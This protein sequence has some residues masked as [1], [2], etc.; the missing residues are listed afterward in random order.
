M[1][2]VTD[3]GMD[4]SPQQREGIELHQVPL[5]IE[6]D[7]RTYRS[8]EDIEPGAFY[9]LLANTHSYP[10]TT[11][12]SPGDFAA[13]YRRLAAD[14][15]DILSVHISSGLSGTINAA[16]LGAEMVPEANVTL[17]D[18]KTLSGG[19]GW[20]VEAA[21]RALKAGWPLDAILELLARIRAAADTMFTLDELRYLVHGGRISHIK[22][23]LAQVL[24]IRPVIG[25]EKVLGKY[26]Q[27]GQARTFARATQ[28]LV[29]QVVARHKPGSPLR[30]QIM[31]A[32][33][34]EGAAE[35]RAKLDAVFACEWLPISHIAPVLGAHT[36]PSMIGVVF[37]PQ[38]LFSELPW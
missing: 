15:P 33:N 32:Y 7:G 19:E 29:D 10:T 3:R 30:L 4:L 20:Q 35:L 8:G 11:Q 12:P 24:R 22:G 2:I 25:V 6:L 37:A 16:R 13:L 21:A 1:Q 18:T 38:A 31:H 36:G 9:Q 5:L 28:L 27:L 14:D 26:E 34:P 23:L 17:V